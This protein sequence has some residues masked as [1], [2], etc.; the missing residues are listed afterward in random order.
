MK[1]KTISKHK[2]IPTSL[3]LSLLFLLFILIVPRVQAAEINYGSLF[4]QNKGSFTL[5]YK[6]P[7]GTS[8]YSCLK[9][10]YSCTNLGDKEPT[11]SI[12]ILGKAPYALSDDKTLAIHALNFGSGLT[13]S[14]FYSLYDVSGTSPQFITLVPHYKPA[15]SVEFSRFNDTILFTGNNGS[16]VTYYISTNTVETTVTEHSSHP[17]QILSAHGSYLSYYNFTNKQHEIVNLRKNT[18]QHIP[19][20]KPSY[21]EFTED[22]RY[23]VFRAIAEDGTHVLKSLLL[24]DPPQAPMVIT[25]S[26]NVIEDYITIGNRT[27]YLA[28]TKDSVYT[29]TITEY[30]H[31]SGKSTQIAT[32]A[33]YGDYMHVI[34]GKLL[35]L[36]IEG[37]NSNIA[38]YDPSTGA[39]KVI[40]PIA[41]SPHPDKLT[42]TAIKYGSASA[43]HIRN[44]EATGAQPL[45]VWLH[46]GP[47]RQTSLGFHSY[48]SYAVYDELL[49]RLADSGA[50]V[51]KLDYAGSFGYGE[52][53]TQRLINNVG[54]ADVNDTITA[55]QE[56]KKLNTVSD[57]YLIGN[58]YG[59]YTAMRTLAEKPELFNGA[60]TINGVYDWFSLLQRIPS[61]PFTKYFGGHAVLSDPSKNIYKYITASINTRVTSLLKEN[62]LIVAGETDTSV[63]TWQSTE[64]Y[65]LL[66][67]F[68]ANV[69]LIK[70]PNEGHILKN[71][72]TLD[73]LC[74]SIRERFLI[75]TLNC[76]M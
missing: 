30:S 11:T 55:V 66:S 4:D 13:A 67:A 18:T 10:P 15:T 28:N 16:L 8:Y 37:K 58:S 57:V 36:V 9:D 17:L 63:P 24:S 42:R 32:N 3:I 61:S 52:S 70:Y 59:A 33:S 44:T 43:V 73:S 64:F 23:A 40:R 46:G 38:V 6:S 56:F 29:W 69:E 19:N 65:Y 34:D 49:E 50:H 68:G 47:E 25:S 74:E 2:H 12:R 62:I 75:P 26:P 5:R 72:D 22:E 54:V 41:D 1:A 7:S 21:L 27:Y 39:S 53:Y 71:R 48:L 20:E 76:S 31:E 14:S 60:I 45:F 51:I 35:F